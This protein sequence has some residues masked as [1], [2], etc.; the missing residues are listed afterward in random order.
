MI[1]GIAERQ[2]LPTGYYSDGAISSNR[3]ADMAADEARLHGFEEISLGCRGQF[4]V[5]VK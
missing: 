5:S 1:G 4:T 3:L 2:I